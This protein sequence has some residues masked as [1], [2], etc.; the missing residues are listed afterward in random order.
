MISL[1]M[2]FRP[3]VLVRTAKTPWDSCWL[4]WLARQPAWAKPA[5]SSGLFF[6]RHPY[7]RR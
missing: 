2:C 3:Y 7:R 5:M 4:V 1:E 6:L